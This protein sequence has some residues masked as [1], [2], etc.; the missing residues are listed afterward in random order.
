MDEQGSDTRRSMRSEERIPR[1][2]SRGRANRRKLLETAE[3]LLAD[4]ARKNLRFSDVFE[5][6]GVSRG[7]AYRIYMGLDDLLHDLIAE[8]L[9]NFVD[10]LASTEPPLAPEDWMVLSDFLVERAAG[11]WKTTDTTLRILPR[12]RS[13]VPESHQQSQRALSRIIGEIFSRNFV[14]P[15]MEDWN[16]VLGFYVQIC[17]ATFSDSV[18]RE[19]RITEQR[20]REAQ[21]LCRTYLAFYLPSWLP[22][23]A[24]VSRSRRS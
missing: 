10:H 5:A 1:L 8:W 23:R 14:L 13:N 15:A 12:I 19:G 3:R 18:R 6:A 4:P 2:R 7:S 22:S 9:N 21:A 11:Y 20:L 17:D 16:A 24:D